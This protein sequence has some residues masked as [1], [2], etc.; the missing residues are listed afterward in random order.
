MKEMEDIKV[1]ELCTFS[2]RWITGCVIV[3]AFGY[4]TIN[5]LDYI[6]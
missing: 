2:A 4:F 1:L 6:I 3:F 5:I